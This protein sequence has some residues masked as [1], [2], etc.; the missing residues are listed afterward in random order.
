MSSECMDV[1]ALMKRCRRK[2]EMGEIFDA[3]CDPWQV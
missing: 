1:W 3:S 2:A